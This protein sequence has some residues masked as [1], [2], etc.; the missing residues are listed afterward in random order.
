MATATAVPK[1]VKTPKPPKPPKQHQPDPSQLEPTKRRDKPLATSSSIEQI[2]ITKIDPHPD[3]RTI[4]QASLDGLVESIREFGQ[5][6]PARV[7]RHPNGRYQIIS[8]ERRFRACKLA[9][10]K[11]LRCIVVIEDDVDALTGLAVAN[12][13][14]KDLDPIERAQAIERLIAK[15]LDRLAAGR[16]VG[17]TSESGVKNALR[18]LKLPPGIQTMIRDGQLSERAARRLI[19]LCELPKV[20]AA[21]E[22]ELGDSDIRDELADYSTY[23]WFITAA[24]TLHTR[25]MDA[26]TFLSSKLVPGRHVNLPKQFTD[27]DAAKANIKAV[28]VKLDNATW[29]VT[30]DVEAW[31]DLQRPLAQAWLA[32]RES[33]QTGEKPTTKAASKK[34]SPKDEAAEADRLAKESKERLTK[35]NA[36]WKL[37]ALRC[38]LAHQVTLQQARSTLPLLFANFESIG[39]HSYRNILQHAMLECSVRTKRV[40]EWRTIETLDAL[41][42]IKAEELLTITVWRY[43]LW[44]VSDSP[45]TT[46]GIRA[47]VV[48]DR[49]T[50]PDLDIVNRSIDD[51]FIKS[52]CKLLDVSIGNFWQDATTPGSKQHVLLGHWLRRQTVAQ[53]VLLWDEIKPKGSTGIMAVKR[54]CIVKEI[55]SAHTLK[56][57]ALPRGIR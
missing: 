48:M 9:K 11:D 4:D 39:Y 21:V 23:P 43:M 8:G 13:N 29:L 46:E 41:P 34:L 31:D 22:Q 56:P 40:G 3:N 42:D 28:M 7:R 18:F 36:T 5:L 51:T 27:V 12:S 37:A 6:E 19:P 55:L 2:D 15:G 20:L 38:Q 52:L 30:E 26:R 47:A 1:R 45:E 49:N 24:I 17:L 10:L 25:P 33:K 16:A 32:K 54:D 44:P 53:L 50:V 57:L 14:R 35:W